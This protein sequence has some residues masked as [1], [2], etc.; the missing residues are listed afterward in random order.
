MLKRMREDIHT[1]FD[2]DPAVR[3]VWEA[4]T[5]YPGLHA[6]W[7]YRLAHACWQKNFLWLGRFISHIA[8]WLTG[9]EIHPV[10]RSVAV[11]L[12]ITAWALSSVKPP[13]LAMM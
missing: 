12:L 7:M 6:I 5:C 13:R 9:N 3:S 4:L 2:R 8:R 10:P 11:S 1:A